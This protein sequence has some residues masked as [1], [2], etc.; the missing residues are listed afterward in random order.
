MET[1]PFFLT[2]KPPTSWRWT[3]WV[4]RTRIWWINCCSSFTSWAS[5]SKLVG[6][7]NATSTILVRASVMLRLQ[8]MDFE[9]V[10]NCLTNMFY[11]WFRPQLMSG[12]LESC[13]WEIWFDVFRF[14]CIQMY[15]GY[16]R[17]VCYFLGWW[18]S[19]EISGAG[20]L[21]K[22]EDA[23]HGWRC[24]PGLAIWHHARLEWC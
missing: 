5:T 13:K 1:T 23:T 11:G 12:A 7:G 10:K 3:P 4:W 20:P 2:K 9:G 6:L 17:T 18:Q 8:T 21:L 19:P 15:L 22:T 24:C 14:R 16:S